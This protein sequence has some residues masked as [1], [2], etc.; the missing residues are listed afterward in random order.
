MQEEQY[1]S[2]RWIIQ[3]MLMLL[4]VGMGL[5]FMAPTPLFP[6]IMDEFEISRSAVSLLVSATIIVITVALLPGGLLIAKMGSKRSMTVAGLFMSAHLLTP[7]I[8]SFALLVA[9]RLLFGMGV[10]ITIPATSAII[11][12]WFKPSE[13]PLLNGITRSFPIFIEII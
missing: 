1:S 9:L 7:L 8:D 10:A 4:Q 13:L 2:H 6:V 5:N 11:M 12:E 3:A